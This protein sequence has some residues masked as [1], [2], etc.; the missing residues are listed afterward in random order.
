LC[1]ILVSQKTQ[2]K[3]HKK[4]KRKKEKKKAPAALQIPSLLKSNQSAASGIR[5]HTPKKN[6]LK[7]AK[8][9]DPLAGFSACLPVGRFPIPR[10][11]Q[12]KSVQYP[13]NP[14]NPCSPIATRLSIFI[15]RNNS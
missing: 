10:H 9:S 13:F 15:Y 14:F 11:P 12:K 2:N 1:K 4:K 8:I 7:S 5:P 3:T 6:Q